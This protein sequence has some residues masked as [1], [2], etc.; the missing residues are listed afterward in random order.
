MNTKEPSKQP[1]PSYHDDQPRL[2]AVARMIEERGTT[3]G[4][5]MAVVKKAAKTEHGSTSSRSQNVKD[6]RPKA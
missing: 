4:N 3:R 1:Q 6:A 5:F 2:P